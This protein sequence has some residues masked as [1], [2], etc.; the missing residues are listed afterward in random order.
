[1]ALVSMKGI[2]TSIE[3]LDSNKYLCTFEKYE[4]QKAGSTRNSSEYDKYSCQFAVLEDVDGGE[5]YAGRKIFTKYTLS[6]DAIVFLKKALLALG[7]DPD[8]LEDED[9]V[10]VDKELTAAKSNK[11][12]LTVEY[13]PP[14]EEGKKPYNKVTAIEPE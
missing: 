14:Q 13:C 8:D 6:E 5:E 11:V 9:G 10:D 2:S 3:P 12:W 4:E 1:M 7:S